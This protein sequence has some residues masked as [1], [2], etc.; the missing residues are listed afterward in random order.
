MCLLVTGGA[1]LG[2]VVCQRLIDVDRAV[3]ILDDLR[4][5][6]SEQPGQV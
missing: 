3:A 6:K 5:G 4:A 1:D 2:S